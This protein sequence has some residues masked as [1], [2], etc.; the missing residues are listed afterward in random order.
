L[1]ALSGFL[2]TLFAALVAALAGG[3]IILRIATRRMLSGS[4]TRSLFHSLIP[5]SV[6]C[7][8]NPPF[9][10]SPKLIVRPSK[11]GLAR[12]FVFNR[13]AKRESGDYAEIEIR[14]VAVSAF[15]R[16]SVEN[17]QNIDSLLRPFG[18][19]AGA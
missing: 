5:L 3:A 2:T 4:F 11:C 1:G 16:Y 15:N 19:V 6:V 13:H 10:C 18:A 17:K 9:L 7:H 12:I 8:I 14:V